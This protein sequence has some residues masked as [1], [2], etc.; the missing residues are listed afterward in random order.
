[1]KYQKSVFVLILPLLLLLFMPAVQ[2]LNH[3]PV[4]IRVKLLSGISTVTLK[5]SAATVIKNEKTGSEIIRSR[6]GTSLTV[7]AAGKYIRIGGAGAFSGPIMV[8][9]SSPTAVKN[10]TYRGQIWIYNENGRLLIINRLDL[11]EYL[12]SVVPMEI[13][14]AWNVNALKAQAIAARSYALAQIAHNN[15]SLYDLD[16]TDR[17]QVYGGAATEQDATTKAV[18][19]TSGEVITYQRKVIAAYFH[20]CCGGAT[21]D[22]KNVWGS[23]L[24]YLRSVKSRYCKGTKYYSWN[25]TLTRNELLALTG[26]S[27]GI[28]RKIRTTA[29]SP[30]GRV[31]KIQ[32]ITTQGITEMTGNEFRMKLGAK[33]ILSTKFT[34]KRVGHAFVLDG[35]GWGHGVGMCQ[36]SAKKM[37]ESGWSY[38]GI[39]A[40]FYKHTKI[41]RYRE[42]M[43]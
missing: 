3:N 34:I 38:R 41:M 16:N 29:I 1:M 37:A 4:M 26:S 22:V 20:A 13:S 17:S 12:Y 7:T 21:A 30:S 31:L 35:Y 15:Y 14:H 33:R 36:W 25:V 19:L 11:E 43:L 8:Y 24:P 6:S 32:I 10:K 27:K 40:F 5:T 28:I 18:R 9:S 39:L 42:N 23:D 2:A